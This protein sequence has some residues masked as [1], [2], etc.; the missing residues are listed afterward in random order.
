MIDCL[1]IGH[2]EMD[3]S[4]Y[5]KTLHLY[6]EDSE[7]YRDLLLN[8]VEYKNKPYH[9]PGLLNEFVK[10]PRLDSKLRLSDI[11]SLTIAYLGSYLSDYE[12]SFDYIVSFQ[13]EM[14]KLRRILETGQVRLTA[15][16]TTLYTSMQPIL[17]IVRFIRDI[18][19]KIKIVIGGP[20]IY[21]Q[22]KVT[23][24][25]K[26]SMILAQINADFYI[27]ENQG[28]Q[29]L[30]EL[31]E[32]LRDRKPYDKIKNIAYFD[33]SQLV[34]NAAEKESNILKEHSVNWKL[35]DKDISGL[36]ATRTAISCPFSCSFCAFPQ[37]AGAYRPMEPVDVER[38]FHHLNQQKNIRSVSI[39][40]DTFNVPLNRFKEILKMKIN[41]GYSFRWNA[42]L[43]CQYLDE[44]AAS[45]MKQSGC[46]GVFLGIES[47]NQVVLDAMN[48]QVSVQDLE[49][50]LSLLKKY[51]IMT[52]ASFIFGF[53]EETGDSINDTCDFI[54]R[55]SPDFYRTQL[56]YYDPLTPVHR[57]KDY[58]QLSGSG[59]CWDHKTMD[60]KTAMDNVEK[61][62]L[63]IRGPVWLTQYNFD[64]L[65]VINMLNK[66]FTLKEIKRFLRIFNA[67]ITRRMKGQR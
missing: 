52:F 64:F 29:A 59:F 30:K 61:A 16:T 44:E 28:E 34:V 62:F 32:A 35:F 17:E 6:G 47:A 21:S 26:L 67:R 45:L 18:N 2:N 53:P 42:Y 63:D 15:V 43:R 66:G 36:V 9:F 11:F 46:E 33:H 54:R 13:D 48:K 24:R 37:H 27:N 20:Y 38:E 50:G 31:A 12:I 57:M 56:W 3:F 10:D 23:G 55:M 4:R 49:C 8:F 1:L 19:P 22:F 58:Y 60:S 40:D 41:N 65:G 5:E 14:E 51:E 25:K 39:I 7:I